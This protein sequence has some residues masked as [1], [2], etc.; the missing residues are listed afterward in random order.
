REH[1]YETVPPA[2]EPHRLRRGVG[3]GG[4]VLVPDVVHAE[5]QGRQQGDDYDTHRP[6]QI[7]RVTDVTSPPGHRIGDEQEGFERIER[8]M[9]ETEFSAFGKRRLKFIYDF[10]QLFLHILSSAL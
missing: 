2:P 10:S 9:R 1:A 4:E 5:Q 7:V 3:N 6:F 8:R